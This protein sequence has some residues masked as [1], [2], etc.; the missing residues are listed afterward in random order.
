MT[1][2]S[3]SSA[4]PSKSR[5]QQILLVALLLLNAIS[6]NFVLFWRH[7]AFDLRARVAVLERDAAVAAAAAAAATS[8][9]MATTDA[10]RHHVV[11]ATPCVAA[12]QTTTHHAPLAPL[13]DRL[14]EGG[15]CT[16]NISDVQVWKDAM[17]TLWFFPNGGHVRGELYPNA[18]YAHFD[19]A[20]GPYGPQWYCDKIATS[21][22]PW[23]EPSGEL[24]VA[25]VVVG[26][27]SGESLFYSRASATTATWSTQ[28]PHSYIY[29]SQAE[30][31]VPVVGLG[32]RYK[33]RP[34]FETLDDVQALQIVAVR[35]MY[36]R[37]PTGKWF[38][39]IGDDV[40]IVA[41]TLVRMLERY[42]ASQELW[43]V[44]YPGER[45]VPP[46]F[47]LSVWP[48]RVAMI[49][50]RNLY[51]WQAGG[52][53]WFISN[54]VAR[55]W[56]E[57]AERFVRAPGI[58]QRC[59]CPDIY[60]GMLLS[61]LGVKPTHLPGDW[62][63][64]LSGASEQDQH[65]AMYYTP[66]PV[67]WHYQHPRRILGAHQWA[68][69]R[70]IDRMVN[71][72]ADRASHN[73][74]LGA[75]H[76]L[77]LVIKSYR[78]FVNA[79]MDVLR[80]W[81]ATMARLALRASVP[82]RAY[83]IPMSGRALL[84]H[85]VDWEPAPEPS[86][87]RTRSTDAVVD[88]TE[89]QRAQQQQ[90]EQ[91]QPTQPMQQDAR[92]QNVASSCPNNVDSAPSRASLTRV[93]GEIDLFFQSRTMLAALLARTEPGEFHC[94][95]NASEAVPPSQTE[96]VG[97]C[98]R[99]PRF[100][101]LAALAAPGYVQLGHGDA[102]LPPLHPGHN[103]EEILPLLLD[104][105]RGTAVRFVQIGS[106]MGLET[107]FWRAYLGNRAHV[108]AI[109]ERHPLDWQLEHE[110]NTHVVEV[111]GDRT[112]V[113]IEYESAVGFSYA[114][115]L[116]KGAC[117]KARVLLGG[118]F[119][120]VFDDGTHATADQR[121]AF[122]ELFPQMSRGGV[123]IV[124]GLNAAYARPAVAWSWMN[125]TKAML[126]TLNRRVHNPKYAVLNGAV[127]QMVHTITCTEDLCAY[128]RK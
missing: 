22:E 110:S 120:V 114:G 85:P 118:A 94:I 36:L 100:V 14:S 49:R 1:L 90:A 53:G 18:S 54:P 61:L 4:A 62:G 19:T 67:M 79:Q 32:A 111:I 34:D 63:V 125:E 77:S 128:V 10:P 80:R 78:S 127:D 87:Q 88:A 12:P 43:L 48:D 2:S 15:L 56:A 86:A 30:P 119:D 99:L 39:I 74:L 89:A 116:S 5:T 6:W 50:E 3:S 29:A 46:E 123:Y 117:T 73:D 26:V 57:H 76:A 25:D 28:F 97:F 11:A 92:K 9:A 101:D 105:F 23:I 60:S 96:Y 41:N 109:D 47:D 59:N 83:D 112:A 91:T 52:S 51:A 38:Y 121:R 95:C 98:E 17:S 70:K 37:H 27:F 7:E 106:I 71:L 124:A 103:Y 104:R 126:D 84:D 24:D 93:R 31:T 21:L 13:I 82:F 113:R 75:R 115:A 108:V 72:I 33:I 107:A 65:S 40:Y 44:Q 122:E 45:A 55:K 8:V 42:D 69:H 35:D 64:R 81:Q 58:D 102:T 68:E 20:S 16:R 66:D